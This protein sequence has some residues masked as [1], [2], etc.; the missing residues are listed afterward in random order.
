LAHYQ[1]INNYEPLIGDFVIW[2]GWWRTWYGIVSGYDVR[3]GEVLIIFAGFPALL[4]VMDTQ[5]Q[6][7]E[8]YKIPLSQLKT[9]ANTK[10]S[11]L[12]NDKKRNTSVWYI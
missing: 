11:I 9:S 10:F 4:F 6:T 7:K 8:T 12:Q 1:N 5:E 2:S 3:S